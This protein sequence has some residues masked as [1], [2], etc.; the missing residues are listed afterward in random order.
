MFKVIAKKSNGESVQSKD[1]YEESIVVDKNGLFHFHV[2]IGWALRKKNL[3]TPFPHYNREIGL[4]PKDVIKWAVI[5]DKVEGLG[6]NIDLIE[7]NEENKDSIMHF[8]KFVKN[9]VSM[10]SN[11]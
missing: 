11:E 3:F 7:L 5:N 6:H 10:A 8:M 4:S 9:I 2:T 1:Y